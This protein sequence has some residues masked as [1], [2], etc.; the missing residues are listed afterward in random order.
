MKVIICQWNWSRN[1]RWY[2][3]S[4]LSW[5]VIQDHVL[6]IRCS[7]F[8]CMLKIVFSSLFWNYLG[9]WIFLSD[10]W[11]RSWFASSLLHPFLQSLGRVVWSFFHLS[12][13]SIFG[14]VRFLHV[15]SHFSNQR[16]R[17]RG[18]LLPILGDKHIVC[19]N[20]DE[21]CFR[22]RSNEVE[23]GRVRHDKV[24]NMENRNHSNYRMIWYL[25]MKA[26][27]HTLDYNWPKASARNLWM[28]WSWKGALN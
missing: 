2:L 1:G 20:P 21:Q 18:R 19:Q 13:S 17:I 24:G 25:K 8:C 28:P 15:L 12:F 23:L 7:V 14:F 16:T 26:I 5:D 22:N 3:R 6:W 4:K 11:S 10:W 27:N 9:L